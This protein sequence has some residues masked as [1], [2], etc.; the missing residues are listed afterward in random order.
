MS[1]K[2]IFENIYYS[3][4]H[5]AAYAAIDKLFQAVRSKKKIKKKYHRENVVDW[6]ESQDAY[7]LHRPVRHRFIRRTYN[8]QNMDDLW[9]ADLMDLRSLKTYNDGYSYV[10]TIIDAVSKYSWL[11][12]IKEKSSKN[13]AEAF[14]RV[15]SRSSG[16]K[17][18][19]LQT[20]KGKEFVGRETQQVLRDNDITHR[21]ARSPDTKAAIAERLIRTIKERIWRYF[22]HKNTRRYIDVLA[23]II[24][25]YNQSKHSAT[26]MTPASVTLYNVAK[27]R[28]NIQQRYK[29]SKLDRAPKFKIGQL[30]R[31]SRARNIFQ[32]SYEGGWTLEIFKIVRIS[33]TRQPPVYFL[34]DLSGEDI[35]GCFYG[36]ELSRVRKNLNAASFEIDKI[37]ESRGTSRSKEYFVSW[38]GYPEKFNSWVKASQLSQK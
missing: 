21:V 9:E 34:Q 3:L 4:P 14:S 20:D 31:V 38:K 30:V 23:E 26:K 8:V 16:R 13:V 6:L 24:E 22:T 15:F 28:K 2:K 29:S 25:A 27:A 17:P 10:L 19:C 33:T 5:P 7:N 18:I 37:L 35:D 1:N 36:E 32:K 11:E 12:P